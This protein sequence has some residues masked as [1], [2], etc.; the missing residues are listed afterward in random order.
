MK[1]MKVN[2]TRRIKRKEKEN[3]R[4]KWKK[5]KYKCMRV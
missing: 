5:K 1:K 3:D 2:A 4:G